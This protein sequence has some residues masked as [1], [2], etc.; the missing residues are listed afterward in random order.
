MSSATDVKYWIKGKC[1]DEKEG[2]IQPNTDD[3]S[4]KR[5]IRSLAYLLEPAEGL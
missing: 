2:E 4:T 5:I 1:S 3:V